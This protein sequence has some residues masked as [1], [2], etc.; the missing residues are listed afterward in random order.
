[1]TATKQMLKCYLLKQTIKKAVK[2]GLLKKI[3]KSVLKEVWKGTNKQQHQTLSRN[4]FNEIFR[5]GQ[6]VSSQYNPQC[7][8]IHS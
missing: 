3:F 5:H 8:R 2:E 6:I 4:F 1:M 7:G